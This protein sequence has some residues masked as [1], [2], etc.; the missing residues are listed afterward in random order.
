MVLGKEIDKRTATANRGQTP[1]VQIALAL[2]FATIVRTHTCTQ[3][4]HRHIYMP[5]GIN[6][7]IEKSTI[8]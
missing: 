3:N 5:A 4:A 2:R 8:S 1:L 7:K 6:W